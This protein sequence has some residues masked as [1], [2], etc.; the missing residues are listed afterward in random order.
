[1]NDVPFNCGGRGVSIT[2]TASDNDGSASER[3]AGHVGWG[4]AD[5]IGRLAGAALREEYDHMDRTS[6]HDVWGLPGE[7]QSVVGE[8]YR[9]S[10]VNGYGANG[11]PHYAA[12]FE[13]SGGPASIARHGMSSSVYQAEFNDRVKEGYR[14]VE[15]SGYTINGEPHYAAI[16]DKSTGPAWIARHGMSSSQYQREFTKRVSEGY[17][18]RQVC[19]Y[20]VGGD[21]QYAA[22]FD[23]STGGGRTL[24]I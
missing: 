23:K 22:I 10:E 21:A 24:M 6:R 9:L 4:P 2:V 7:V 3:I 12:I 11:Q 19:G 15:V 16:F 5:L 1:M 13:K 17:R 20:A 18:L 14:L 8:G